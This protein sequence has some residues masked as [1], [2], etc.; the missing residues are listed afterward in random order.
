MKLNETLKRKRM[1][2]RNLISHALQ[3]YVVST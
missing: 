3:A 1:V 2:A